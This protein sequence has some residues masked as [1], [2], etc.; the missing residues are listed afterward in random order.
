[1]ARDVTLDGT[2]TFFVGVITPDGA[3]KVAERFTG[4]AP[5]AKFKEVFDKLL[6]AKG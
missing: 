5:F 1:M 6:A 3:L 2:P 4:A